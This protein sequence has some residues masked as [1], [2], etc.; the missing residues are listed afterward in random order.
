MS[1][2]TPIHPLPSQILQVVRLWHTAFRQ[3]EDLLA[4]GRCSLSSV[5]VDA[6][7]AVA[8]ADLVDVVRTSGGNVILDTKAVELAFQGSVSTKT[9]RLPWGHVDGK[10]HVPQDWI[11]ENGRRRCEAIA[12]FAVEKGVGTVL[13]PSHAISGANDPWFEVDQ[14]ALEMLRRALDLAG[15]AQ[16]QIDVPLV[17]PN[18]LFQRTDEIQLLRVRLETAEF[19]NLWIRSSGFGMKATGGG[20]EKF[21]RGADL[22]G[23]AGHPILADC[24]AGMPGLAAAA[25]GSICGVAHGAA[26]KDQFRVENLKRPR[27]SDSKFG[28]PRRIYV[29]SIDQHLTERVA[30]ELLEVRGLRSL[31][32]CNDAGCCPKGFEDTVRNNRGHA[33]NQM[34]AQLRELSAQPERQRPHHFQAQMLNP[35]SLALARISTTK[36]LPEGLKK[37]LET[38]ANSSQRRS[39]AFQKLLKERGETMRL[40]R[41]PTFGVSCVRKNAEVQR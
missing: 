22:L 28:P 12:E 40:A 38:A 7:H 35:V 2:V 16:I 10:P 4:A 15:G 17:L 34:A 21:V 14:R 23:E 13:A 18:S 41:V 1:N 36:A 3:F 37:S 26:E 5:V 31:L 8:Q 25:L 30:R 39:D 24:V 32:Q 9:S 29:R 11:G 33:V 27:P 6:A 20:L 19:G